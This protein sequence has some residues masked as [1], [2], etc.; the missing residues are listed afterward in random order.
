MDLETLQIT[1][2]NKHV[3]FLGAVFLFSP[4]SYL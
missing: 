1:E 2:K 3:G 4:G